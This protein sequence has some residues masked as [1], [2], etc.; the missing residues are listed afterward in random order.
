[1]PVQKKGGLGKGL[2]ALFSEQPVLKTAPAA[3]P[4]AAPVPE[5]G[6]TPV[7]LIDIN[8]ITPNRSQPRKTFD[9]EKL[10]EL[11]ESIRTHGLIQ[12]IIVQKID[13]G[14]EIVAGERRW[15]ASR[16]AECRQIP[17]IVRE[18]TDRENMLVALIENLQRED[19]NPMEEAEAFA[20]M[21]SVHQMT[22]EAIAES[23]GKIGVKRSRSYVTNTLR[24][25]ELPEDIR[26]M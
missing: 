14:Y 11:A 12:P 23:I 6:S 10:E 1:M 20:Q 22:H 25:R 21:V 2:G 4:A 5:D 19:L 16:L 8:E 7:V 17:C 9:E 18:F 13:D 24:L 3:E 26:K 15:R